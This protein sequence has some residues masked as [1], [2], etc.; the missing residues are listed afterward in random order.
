MNGMDVKVNFEKKKFNYGLALLRF[1]MCFEVVLC[2][3]WIYDGSY[4]LISK[5]LNYLRSCAV[6]IF[7]IMSFYLSNRLFINVNRMTLIKRIKR[8]IIPYLSWSLIYLI[9]LDLIALIFD[10]GQFIALS[11][12]IWQ[13]LFGSSPLLNP[14]MWYITVS[15]WLTLFFAFLARYFL[16]RMDYFFLVLFI[17]AILMEYFGIN[18][19]L[20]GDL[21]YECKYTLGRFTEMM[22]YA[23]MGY[24]LAKKNVFKS[25][26]YTCRKITIILISLCVII[27]LIGILGG[28]AAGFGYAGIR[29]MIIS[30]ILFSI[31]YWLPINLLPNSVKSCIITLSRHTFGI[32]C[33]H[34]FIG[35]QIVI[36]FNYYNL[37][38]GNLFLCF[39]LYLVCYLIAEVISRLPFAYAK[40]IVD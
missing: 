17:V 19:A 6:P 39:I 4:P 5:P 16:S 32:Y 7:M 21:P 9:L 35:N 27:S 40:K 33:M 26:T 18:V 34:F 25:L 11:D 3:F 28:E 24:C 22:P 8:L 13:I 31:F 37:P 15:I 23:I 14:A 1:F 10:N 29:Y 20:F 30:V 38:V 2:H 12:F 36:V